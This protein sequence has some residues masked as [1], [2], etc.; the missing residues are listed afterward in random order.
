MK[1]LIWKL[2]M[3]WA[4]VFAW[5]VWSVYQGSIPEESV[6]SFINSLAR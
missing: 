5:F 2:M 3:L 1:K 6:I 4:A